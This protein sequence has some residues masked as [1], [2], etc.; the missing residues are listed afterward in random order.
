MIDT[1]QLYNEIKKNNIHFFSGVPDSVLKSFSNTIEKNS[2]NNII[3]VNEGSAIGLG[4]GYYLSTNKIPCIYFQNSGLGNAINPLISIAHNKVY[5]IP[6]LLIIGW[7]GSPKVNNDE[8]QHNVK[9][10]ITRDILKLLNIK[11]LI[12]RRNKDLKKN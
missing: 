4:I 9:G 8:P 5:S 6:I 12:L 3:A 10:K 11:T 1:K 2:K 7:R